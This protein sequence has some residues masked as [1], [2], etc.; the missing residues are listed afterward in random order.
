MGD[1]VM[2]YR[3]AMAGIRGVG[4]DLARQL[5]DIV[6]DEQRFFDM[7]EAELRT[8]TGGRSRIYSEAYRRGQLEQA[9]REWEF[10][11]EK[12]ITTT[13]YTDKA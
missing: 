12:G 11:Q 1:D 5:L 10:V 7:G 8:I 3:M 2:I 6:G 9:R 4:V 13:Y